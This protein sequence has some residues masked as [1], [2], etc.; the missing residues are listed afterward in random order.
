ML[1]IDRSELH[2][3]ADGHFSGAVVWSGHNMRPSPFMVLPLSLEEN[4]IQRVHAVAAALT[5]DLRPDSVDGHPAHEF[6]VIKDGVIQEDAHALAELLQPALH[7]LRQHADRS[8]ICASSARGRCTPCTC[9]IRR[10]RPFER[11]SHYEHVDGHAAVTAVVSLSHRREYQGGLF[12]SNLTTRWWLPLDVGE[13][14]VHASDLFH[15]VHVTEGERWS[16]VVWFR[17]CARCT[18]A[19]AGDWYLARAVAGEPFGAFLH[20]SRASQALTTALDRHALAARWYN[21][22]ALGGFALIVC[23]ISH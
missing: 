18:M 11:R 5:F 17:T 15:G 7:T 16:L 8:P 4:V 1:A 12:L 9:L 6:Y 21:V 22:S 3:G 13:A 19:G 14:V 23:L 20:A 10:Y 2:H